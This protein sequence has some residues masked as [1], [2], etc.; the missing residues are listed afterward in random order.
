L[1][2]FRCLTLEL[3]SDR[4]DE[5]TAALWSLD[6]LGIEIGGKGGV[7]RLDV[8]FA[9]EVPAGLEG[10]LSPFAAGL[11]RREEREEVDQDWL[12]T[13]RE[14][15]RPIEVGSRWL[16]D[17]REPGAETPTAVGRELLRVPARRA[18]GTG[19]HEST[20]LIL[21]WMEDLD[22]AGRRVLDLGSGSAI[23][24]IAAE[25][26]GAACVVGVDIDPVACFVASDNRRL[27]DSVVSL[28]AGELTALRHQSFDLALV[29]I[30]P[31]NWVSAAPQL[32]EVLMP[33]ASVLFSGVPAVDRTDFET[34]LAK[35]G[36]PCVEARFEGEWSALRA[37]RAA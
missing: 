11:V 16:I 14:A 17:P 25:R 31:G 27:N 29:N 19:S 26:S 30:L 15:A 21:A 4:E 18:F 24:S 8:W 34:R 33:S 32:A 6:P 1:K 37:E 20:R 28:V 7:S 3:P 23:L 10:V 5:L 13:W 2:R 22:L 12:T 35:A 36:M 9:G